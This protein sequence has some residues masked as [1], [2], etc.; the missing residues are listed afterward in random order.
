MPLAYTALSKLTTTS[1]VASIS[2]T[3][4]P[5]TYTDLSLFISGR[6]TRT[7]ANVDAVNVGFNGSYANFY[8][9]RFGWNGSAVFGGAFTDNYIGVCTTDAASTSAIWGNTWIYI[10]SYAGSTVKTAFADGTS[11]D[12]TA[13]ADHQIASLY[14]SQTSAITEINLKPQSGSNWVAGTKA[15]LY[16]IKN[17]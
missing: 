15:I 13:T 8:G 11:E 16:G 6:S 9:L 5:G 7:N 17:S 1:A 4:I 14:W 2:F 12:Q 10:P 3:S